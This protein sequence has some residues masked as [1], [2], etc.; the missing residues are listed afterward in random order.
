ML[1][2]MIGDL[3]A[4]ADII[5]VDFSANMMLAIAWHRVVKRWKMCYN[6]FIRLGVASTTIVNRKL[7]GCLIS[8]YRNMSASLEEWEMLWE[9]ELLA[10]V[11]T[12]SWSSPNLHELE[13]KYPK[14]ETKFFPCNRTIVE[15]NTVGVA[16]CSS[17]VTILMISE[18]LVTVPL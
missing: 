17:P 12:A 15:S 18:F 16:L 5:P 13:K 8:S 2:S 6:V 3:N 10:S 4:I 9:H 1:R 7:V 11:S 14:K